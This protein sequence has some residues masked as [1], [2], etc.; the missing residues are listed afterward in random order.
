MAGIL[1]F[2]ALG[3]ALKEGYQVCDRTLN[4]ILVRKW[5]PSGWQMAVVL[6]PR[7]RLPD[8]GESRE[9]RLNAAPD[10]EC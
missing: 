5:F 1:T 7:N 10:S 3:D 9:F 2:N 8:I 6:S 4:G